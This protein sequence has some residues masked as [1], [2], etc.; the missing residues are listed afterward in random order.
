MDKKTLRDLSILIL[1]TLSITFAV[2]LPHLLRLNFYGLNFAEGF[3]TIY[4][5]FDGIEYIIIAKSNYAERIIAAM[6]QELP[7]TYYAAHFPLY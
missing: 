6:P 5:N 2:W 4:R 1:S 7:H 3:N